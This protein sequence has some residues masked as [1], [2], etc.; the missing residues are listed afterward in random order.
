MSAPSRKTQE[1]MDLD[2]A[3][4]RWLLPRLKAF[5]KLNSGKYGGH[6]HGMT[7]KEYQAIL[8]KIIRGMEIHIAPCRKKYDEA[9]EIKEALEVNEAFK[10]LGEHL[11][12]FW[13]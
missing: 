9:R 10:L 4:C 5:K 6:P 13:Y 12:S 8:G 11:G 7:H 3:L 1:I 2:R